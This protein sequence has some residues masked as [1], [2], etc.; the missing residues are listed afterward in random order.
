M[1]SGATS[2]ARRCPALAR[3]WDGEVAAARRRRA[4]PRR[5]RRVPGACPKRRRPASAPALV[6]S[7]RPRDRSV[8]RLPAARRR[9]CARGGTRRRAALPDGARLRPDRARAARRCP[10]RGSSS[11]PGCYPTAA[12]LALRRSPTPGCSPGDV[13]IDAKSGVS[14]AGKAPSERTHFSENHGSVAAYGVFSHRHAAEIEQELERRGDLRAAPGAA[15]PR[16]PRD[17]LRAPRAGHDRRRRRRARCARAYADAPFVRLPATRCPRSSTSPTRTSATSAGASTKPRAASSS[18]RC[19]DNLAQGRRRPGGPELQRRARPR[20]DGRGCCDG[21]ARSVLK[22]GGELL[23]DAARDAAPSPAR[24][25]A[26]A[27]AMPAGRRPRRRPRDRRGAGEAGIAKRQV[28]GLRVTDD[29]DARRRRGGAGR[30]DQHAVRGGLAAAGGAGRRPDRRRRGVA[31]R[32]AGA[33]APDASAGA[34]WRSACVGQPVARRRAAPARAPARRRL[35][36]GRRQHRRGRRRRALQRERRHAGRRTSPCALGARAPGH[37]RRRR[38][39]CSTATGGRSPARRAG[40]A[41]RWS[42]TARRPPAW[43]RSSQACRARARRRRGRSGHRG[44]PRRRRGSR[45]S[46]WPAR[47]RQPARPR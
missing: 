8:G 14:G 45:R 12:L 3:I 30:R 11:C 26:R 22:L 9:R 28:D 17:D 27:A 20:R 47:D 29:A 23:E 6:D 40:R 35:R 18:C 32:R 41:R 4:R 19:L 15:R 2:A 43:W 37:R 5:R 1:S 10:A 46:C 31:P 24:S 21:R 7:G 16:H 44:R 34:R 36:A 38:P 33:A 42:P 25:P 39:A 13:I